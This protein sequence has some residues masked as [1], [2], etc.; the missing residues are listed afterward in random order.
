MKL[1]HVSRFTFHGLI[2]LAAVL[3]CGCGETDET[4]HERPETLVLFEPNKGLSL[5][6]EI[7]RSIGVAV[8]E[9]V[10]TNAIIAVPASALIEGAQESFVYVDSSGYFVRTPVKTGAVLNGTIE[11]TDGLTPGD[12]VVTSAAKDLWMVEL[13]ALRGGHACCEAEGK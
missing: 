10:K 1:L 13:L 3:L 9:V 4:E 2:L 5:P 11:I 7:K 6:E 12:R 8:V